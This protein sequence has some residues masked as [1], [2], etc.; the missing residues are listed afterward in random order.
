MKP[1]EKYSKNKLESYDSPVDIDRLWNSMEPKLHPE[2]KKRFPFWMT[3]FSL[4][5]LVGLG[6]FIYKSYPIGSDINFANPQ[7]EISKSEEKIS[8]GLP[9]TENGVIS[10]KSNKEAI[11]SS[12]TT[13]N[14]ILVADNL[15]V[16][17][18]S[19]FSNSIVASSNLTE[20]PVISSI[21]IQEEIQ[22]ENREKI[23][24]QKLNTNF[25]LLNISSKELPSPI[26][27][28]SKKLN[29]DCY[30][31]RN[32]SPFTWHA[33]VYGGY[34]VPNKE[35]KSKTSEFSYLA[36]SRKNSE[37][38]LEGVNVGA[39]LGA[40][41]KSGILLEIGGEYN[42]INERFDW[43]TSRRDT[44]TIIRIIPIQG[45]GSVRDTS[46]QFR[47]FSSQKKIYNKYSFL[48]VPIALGYEFNTKSKWNPYIKAGVSLNLF[49]DHKVAMLDIFGNPVTY[50]DTE[51]SSSTP[52]ISQIGMSFF[53][54]L[55]AR[56]RVSPLISVFG[57]GRFL[58]QMNDITEGTYPL[59]Q[60]YS[61]PGFNA[62]IQF[63]F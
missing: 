26:I 5:A 46:L 33:G 52:F 28:N 61:L 49:M 24:L 54:T 35:L 9:I 60:R 43:K 19:S 6:A 62:G 12:F 34:Q 58:Q 31:F 41:H 20:A 57:E 17:E 45:G 63:H 51:N 10:T 37:T 36:D 18:T 56:Y 42:R 3:L 21:D 7:N 53:G 14:K 59:S 11:P 32:K 50:S 47:E 1:F 15:P 29:E 48:S 2:K 30:A 27:F 39:Y 16:S 22:K 40:K 38:I 25:N 55:G 4:V 13:K 8:E 23:E 44:I